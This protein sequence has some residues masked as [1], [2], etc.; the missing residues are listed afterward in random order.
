MWKVLVLPR[1]EGAGLPNLSERR[2]LMFK[3]G[4]TVRTPLLVPSFSSRIRD[5]EKIFR[6]SEE[7]IDG[8]FLISAYDVKNKKINPP[9]DFSGPVFL[10]SGGYEVSRDSDL[11]DV[12]DENSNPEDWPESDYNSVVSAWTVEFPTVFIS[13]DHPKIRLPI[14]EQIDRAK[15]F[16]MPDGDSM[17]EILLK[18]EK[19]QKFLPIENIEEHVRDLAGFG[20]IGVTEKEVGNSIFQRML[21]IAT[22]RRALARVG[23]DVPLHVFGS[24][25][26]VT[27][28]FYFVAGA[29]VFDGLTWL[30]YAFKDGRTYY[31]QDFG[32]VELGID[33]KAPKIEALCW[34]RN[35]QYMKELQRGMRRFL[36]NRDFGEFGDHGDRIR[37]ALQNVHEELKGKMGG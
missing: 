31:R 17:R 12:G 30:R 15:K 34:S 25:D 21:N 28:L 18:P 9:F 33:T 37:A 16:V 4:T 2:E 32:T 3:R 27:T 35:Y 7:I 24:L 29:D 22:L 23:I 6:A 8:P 5:I 26:T 14:P 1:Q 36:D 13:Y 10:D 20:A 19:G 11:S